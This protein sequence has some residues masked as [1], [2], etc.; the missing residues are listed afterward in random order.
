MLRVVVALGAESLLYVDG[1]LLRAVSGSSGSRHFQN[2]GHRE[3]GEPLKAVP[4]SALQVDQNR[5]KFW[6]VYRQ[7]PGAHLSD[8]VIR[9]RTNL[10]FKV[11]LQ[12]RCSKDGK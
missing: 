3:V 11:T 7:E 10:P 12:V 9:R 4:Q 8:F 2:S 5:F 6:S 1:F